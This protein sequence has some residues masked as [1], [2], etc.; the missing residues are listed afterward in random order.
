MSEDTLTFYVHEDGKIDLLAFHNNIRAEIAD[1][2]GQRQE[3]EWL[4][5]FRAGKWEAETRLKESSAQ[6][7]QSW[8][9]RDAPPYAA[10]VKGSFASPAGL[11]KYFDLEPGSFSLE[12]SGKRRT[13]RM[14]LRPGPGGPAPASEKET[15]PTRHGLPRFLF[16]PAR[17]KVV[18]AEGLQVSPRGHSAELDVASVVERLERNEPVKVSFVFEI[19]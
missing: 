11:A 2:K 9:M 3:K 1:T 4:A 7:V 13:F 14:S 5:S 10:A 12:K 19:P 15:R 6:A 16:V 8:L 18:S 17:G